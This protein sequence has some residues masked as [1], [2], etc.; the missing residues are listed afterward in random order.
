MSPTGQ[1]VANLA[2]RAGIVA[3]VTS[4]PALGPVLNTA[5]DIFLNPQDA[6]APA[7]VRAKAQEEIASA[8]WPANYKQLALI[9]LEDVI[10]VYEDFYNKHAGELTE[11]ELAQVLQRIGASIK[12]GATVGSTGGAVPKVY[13]DSGLI[14]NVQ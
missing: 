9:S 12:L 5:A 3:V 1:L 4:N 11:S 7:A 10:L 8:N 14:V 13:T 2:V 6:L